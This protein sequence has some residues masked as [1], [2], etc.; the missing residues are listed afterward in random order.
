MTTVLRNAGL[1]LRRSGRGASPAS[2]AHRQTHEDVCL[3]EPWGSWDH[4]A[5][6]PGP[7]GESPAVQAGRQAVSRALYLPSSGCTPVPLASS[8]VL[9]DDMQAVKFTFLSV[10]SDDFCQMNTGNRHHHEN[11]VQR[12][13]LPNRSLGPCSWL[14]APPPSPRPWTPLVFG[15]A[16]CFFFFFKF[17]YLF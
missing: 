4:E 10:Q 14:S 11:T 3:P 15:F 2:Q 1:P 8:A 16:F 17:I 13:C 9:G 7:P 5:Q 12:F 6:V